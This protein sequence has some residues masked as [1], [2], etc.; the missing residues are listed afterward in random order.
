MNQDSIAE[1]LEALLKASQLATA[2]AHK[3][4]ESKKAEVRKMKTLD[5]KKE[6]EK[7]TKL[8]HTLGCVEDERNELMDAL[9]R[10]YAN[11][12]TSMSSLFNLL[13]TYLL[14]RHESSGMRGET[15][16]I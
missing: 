4:L 15:G 6:A 16:R 5:G 10:Q 13:G 14:S 11:P 12:G 8:I 2:A 1:D 7:K 9:R 3:L